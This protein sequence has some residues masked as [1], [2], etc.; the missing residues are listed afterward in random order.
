MALCPG[1]A[2]TLGRPESDFQPRMSLLDVHPLGPTVLPPRRPSCHH[3]PVVD[4]KQA[5][6]RSGSDGI[7][8][9][10]HSNT[11]DRS[12]FSSLN[13]SSNGMQPLGPRT[14]G[15]PCTMSRRRRV[16]Y[17]LL[18]SATP[19]DGQKCPTCQCDG[20]LRHAKVLG[21]EIYFTS[22]VYGLTLPYDGY[23]KTCTRSCRPFEQHCDDPST[24]SPPPPASMIQIAMLRTLR[25]AYRSLL[26]AK[27][28]HLFRL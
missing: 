17:S 3:G 20:A 4:Q 21:G 6:S 25:S 23:P 11:H 18:S 5:G 26:V 14:Y 28:K 24:H 27:D 12:E 19:V 10:R 7:R 13:Y 9:R 22:T 16:T 1:F 2:T 15:L 8:I